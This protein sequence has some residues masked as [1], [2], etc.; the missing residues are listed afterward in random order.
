MKLLRFGEKG[1]ENPGLWWNGQR[2][3]CSAWFEDWNA[4]FFR[5]GGLAELNS[6]KQDF[7][8]LPTVPENER[9]AAPISR[10]AL[11]VC[12][13]LNY[14]DHAKESGLAAPQEPIL[15]LKPVNTISGP[16]DPVVIPGGAEKV[17][18]ELELAFVLEKDVYRLDSEAEATAAI[19]GYTMANDLSERSYQ[20]ERG[21]QWS[22]GKSLPGFCPLGPWLTT[23]EE[24]A[25]VSDLSM[26]LSVNDQIM[27]KG[28]TSDMIFRPAFILKYLSRF[29]QLEAGDL[30]LTGTP[31][32]VAMGRDA[33]TYLKSG[34]K[35]DCSIDG[36][37]C[38]LIN[39][40]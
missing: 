14:A 16:F 12:I 1:K 35:L 21:G 18:W 2:K 38:Q 7:D 27:Q 39:F 15:F 36:M 40:M 22:K 13:G 34:D 28:N 25:D 10:P 20:M 11:M 30:V 24:V 3:D 31:A 29:M 5:Q 33:G 26:Q 37:G 17:D 9:W 19:A 8:A 6:R 4:E 23:K 32:G